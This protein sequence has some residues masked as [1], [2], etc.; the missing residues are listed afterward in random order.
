MRTA[1]SRLCG[2]ADRAPSAVAAQSSL[3]TSEGTPTSAAGRAWVGVGVVEVAGI[4][5]GIRTNR[6]TTECVADRARQASG[7]TRLRRGRT[8]PAC[9]RAAPTA[10]FLV[11][12]EE[13]LI[14]RGAREHN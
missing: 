14:V 1:V 3:S 10:A 6:T 9:V 12:A 5:L 2:H 13:N 8:L 7:G 11:M 4:R